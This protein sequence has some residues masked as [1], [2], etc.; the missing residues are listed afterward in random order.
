[1]IEEPQAAPATAE[2]DR[3]LLDA[4]LSAPR[5]GAPL[6]SR[7]HL[8]DAARSSGRR[9]V[10]ITA[11][12][13]YG[14]TT[15]LA[16]W[17]ERDP[18]RVVWVTLD[19]FDDD[20][21][22]LLSVLAAALARQ[23]LG[24]P[25]LDG[26]MTGPHTSLLGRAAPR[27]ASA[28]RAAT[29]PFVLVL[30]DLHELR[31]PACHDALGVVI[32]GIPP[33]SQLV[34]AS[35]DAQPHLA[36][37]RATD[38]AVELGA[39]DLALDA[40]GTAQV[41]AATGVPLPPDVVTAVTAR[42]EGWPVGVHLAALVARDEGTGADAASLTGTDPSVADYLQREALRRLP[43]Q[44]RR[45]LRRT[46]V[47]DDLTAPLCDAVLRE[48]SS[49]RHL[50]ELESAHLFVVP[51]DRHRR[52]FRYHAL[53]RE[54]LLDELLTTEPGVADTLRVRAADWYEAHGSPA[55]AVE[56]LLAIDGHDRAARLVA[57]V[58]MPLVQAGQV[59]TVDRWL[60]ALGDATIRRHPTL[61]V[62][63]GYV[64][65]YE[66]HAAVAERWGAVVE[67]A[68]IEDAHPDGP[69][70]FDAARATYRALRCPDG[71][72]RM[73]DDARLALDA[74]PAWGSWRDTAL[75]LSADAHRLA[76]D[77]GA[78]ARHLE[79][80]VEAAN[81]LH[82]ADTLVH[83]QAQLAD[84]DMDRGRWDSAEERVRQ[85]LTTIEEQRTHDYP[86]SALGYAVAARLAHHARDHA[87]TADLL[88]R[89]MRART[90][91][92]YAFPTLAVR[93]RLRLARTSWATGD[94]AAVR[95]LL[96][97][98]DDV[99]LRRPALGVLVD[100]VADLR[101]SFDAA[102]HATALSGAG[103]PLTPAELRLL[104][105]LQTH[106]TIREIGERL[107]V[108][109]NTASSEIGSIYRKLGVS[110]RSAAVAVA[111]DRGLLGD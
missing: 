89:G 49:L 3:L 55:R 62:L 1:M 84:L 81:V 12:P 10:G 27:L 50:R 37:L 68:A 75:V 56:Q 108:S 53:F 51:L 79:A 77:E 71:P 17:V 54:L 111:V 45:F 104:P 63:A 4:K 6:V 24:P 57:R 44:T 48:T 101:K 94:V 32:A 80:C 36:R 91:S 90:S 85:V 69:G 76:G 99:L 98:I 96:R 28:L 42:T 59:S 58:V 46:A 64:A 107:F 11:P 86:T 78:A 38:E 102:D 83:A 74:E 22:T 40:A 97:E 43:D 7:A 30:D 41:F 92:T 95:H 73:L 18:R 15:L 60:D 87:R 47:L 2:L 109:R 52:W 9:V 39:L 110:S 19:R 21:L 20:P 25:D 8:V 88:T 93:V 14:K 23:G 66:G 82:H 72:Q 31:S 29:H 34:A 67:T 70:A 106:L 35:R 33:G 100:E 16:E 105:Y 61:A 13:G 65:V 5:S 103:P 26:G